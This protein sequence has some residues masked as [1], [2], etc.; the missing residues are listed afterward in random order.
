MTQRVDDAVE[1]VR[2]V[3]NAVL[4]PLGGDE[5]NEVLEGLLTEAEAWKKELAERK[6]EPL[7]EEEPE[8]DEEDDEDKDSDEDSDSDEGDEEDS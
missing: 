3:K 6:G 7:E 1:A 4:E 2:K 8:S 5:Y